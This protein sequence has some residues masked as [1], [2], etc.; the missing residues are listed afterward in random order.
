[1]MQYRHIR[2]LALN[3]CL[4]HTCLC[5]KI[6]KFVGA[7][8][9]LTTGISRLFSNLNDR[10]FWILLL[11]ALT[12][13]PV[14]HKYGGLRFEQV[15]FLMVLPFTLRRQGIKF[16]RLSLIWAI[17]F[18]LLYYLLHVYSAFYIGLGLAVMAGLSATAYQ[19]TRLSYMLIAITTPALQYLF[20][21]FS[22][23]IR[24]QLTNLA[25]MVLKW[26]YPAIEMAGNCLVLKGVNYTIAPEC[27]GL[28]MLSSALVMAV[29]ALA[30]WGKRY[31]SQAGLPVIVLFALVAFT[32]VSAGNVVRIILTVMFSAMP[33]TLMHELIGLLVFIINTCLPLLLLGAWASRF[34]KLEATQNL[35]PKK[36]PMLLTVLLVMLTGGAYFIDNNQVQEAQAPLELNI[37]GMQQ[38]CSTDGVVKMTNDEVLIYLKPPAFFLGSDHHPFICWRASGYHIKN[39]N[40]SQVAGHEVYTFEIEKDGEAPLYS[41]WWYSNG[42]RHTCS[43]LQW[44]L[45][46]LK[47]DKPYSVVNVSAND[48]DRC[49]QMVEEILTL[50]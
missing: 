21:V 38:S 17:L 28:N 41:C 25:G 5:E 20:Q 6:L 19:P 16:E 15:L 31:Q 10:V 4:N 34:F 35:Q 48:K 40:V 39:E 1:M 14:I 30:F 27:L 12:A 36:L 37:I 7:V 42:K 8:A 50:L 26:F 47:G 11:M 24:L 43:Q 45:A 33:D 32:L 3:F 23:T 44:R 49:L 2:Q 46:S 22:F 9:D 13:A 18:I 29:F